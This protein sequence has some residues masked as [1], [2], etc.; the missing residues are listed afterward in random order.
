MPDKSIGA[1]TAATTPVAS[2]DIAIVSRDGAN[3]TRITVA[4]LM[5]FLLNR[6]SN[7]NLGLGVTPSA[8]AGPKV[9]QVN[10]AASLFAFGSADARLAHNAYY[11]GSVYRYITSSQ[12]SMY[13]QTG[14]LH[15]WS[16]APSGTAGAPIPFTQAMTLTQPGTLQVGAPGNGGTF[17]II[18]GA[19][20]GIPNRR[21]VRLTADPSGEFDFFINSNQ[22]NP[23]FRWFNG[24]GPSEL[25]QLTSA[26]NLLV[27]TTIEFGKLAVNGNIYAG[28]GAE[29]QVGNVN[30][31]NAAAIKC[32]ATDGSSN[33]IIK[34]AANGI[35]AQ[36]RARITSGGYFKASNTGTYGGAAGLADL[37]GAPAHVIQANQANENAL[38]VVQASAT[39]ANS[40]ASY[41]QAGSTGVHFRGSLN[42]SLV[43]QVLANGNVQNTNN[44]YGAISD[45]KLKNVIGDAPS[46]WQKYKLVEWVKYTLKADPTNQ[47]MLGVIAQQVEG[48]FPGLIERTPDMETV[49]LTREVEQTRQVTVTEQQERSRTEIQLI[50]GQYREVTIT[51]TVEVQVPQFDEFPLFDADGDPLLDQVAPAVLDEQGNV[52]E[53]PFYKQR[54]HRVPRMESVTVTEEYT[55][56]QPTGTETLAVKYSILGHI[57]D[58]VLQEAMQR[59]EDLEARLA[60]LESGK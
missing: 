32:D 38:Y 43:Y 44:S 56:Q 11:D 20:S 59:I 2:T 41:L 45:A 19:S 50:D 39:G 49:T 47:E 60:E 24:V 25:M 58:V 13:A 34:T 35:A 23:K 15:A 53:G 40:V 37:S 6:D 9:L 54:V 29:I 31:T 36:E 30:N 4:E 51:E 22:N 17:E 33:F 57:S 21:G 52:V 55:E 1:L 27:G 42:G 8:W 5:A 48:I 26:G 46:Y 18:P 14:G 28:A 3:L 10:G 7:G 12:S 16:T